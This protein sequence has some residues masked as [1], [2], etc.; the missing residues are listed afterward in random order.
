MVCLPNTPNWLGPFLPSS[1]EVK[2]SRL[3]KSQVA[4]VIALLERYD[5]LVEA[6]VID[7]GWHKKRDLRAFRMKQ[8]DI[9]GRH[10]TKNP[11]VRVRGAGDPTSCERGRDV[12]PSVYAGLDDIPP[13]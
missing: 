4:A 1:G 2:G 10:A 13:C 12:K 8:A 3:N 9:I 6:Q 5:V 7:A 11:D